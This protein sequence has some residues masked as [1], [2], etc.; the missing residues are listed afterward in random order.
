MVDAAERDVGGPPRRVVAEAFLLP[1]L[2]RPSEVLENAPQQGHQRVPVLQLRLCH[3]RQQRLLSHSLPD[4]GAAVLQ[5]P[6]PLVSHVSSTVASTYIYVSHLS[7]S[8]TVYVISLV[9]RRTVV[10]IIQLFIY[11]TYL[12]VMAILE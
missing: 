12:L 2:R 11:S 1:E 4:A 8:I 7:F 10:L 9:Y 6:T 5:A 3:P